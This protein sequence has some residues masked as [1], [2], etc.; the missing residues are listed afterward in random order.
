[1][2]Y[3]RGTVY[4]IIC[5]PEP[6]IQYV[7][8]TYDEL[9]Y[10]WQRHKIQ[11]TRYLNGNYRTV[12]IF[13]YFTQY[14][15][16]NFKII[17]IKDYI[18]YRE[19]QQDHKHLMAY[20]T[21]WINKLKCV[22][23][24]ISFNPIPANKLAL[25]RYHQK[26]EEIN[27]KRRVTNMSLEKI[28]AR[29]KRQNKRGKEKR[30]NE[31]AEEKDERNKKTREK[32]NNKTEEEKAEINKKRREKNAEKRKN[33]TEEERDARL[34]KEREARAKSKAKKKVEETE[35]QKK[36]RLRK[37]REAKAKKRENETEEERDARLKKER[38]ARAK[39][40][41]KEAQNNLM[42]NVKVNVI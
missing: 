28:E 25:L 37:R 39:R 20:E 40:K 29:R 38:E 41:E 18:V 33:E 30:A 1:M 8:E 23:T 11:Y 24:R 5:I 6:T 22:N 12:A 36:E 35:E 42:A 19:N 9:R 15:I 32:R 17:K 4:R 13:P 7:G 34:K 2:P 14:G 21:L 16:E 31:T 10:R 26:K 3:V 27:S